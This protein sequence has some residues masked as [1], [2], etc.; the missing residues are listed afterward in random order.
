[1]TVDSD[2][3]RKRQL[4]LL[5]AGGIAVMVLALVGSLF[6]VHASFP[7]E[8]SYN[9]G[10]PFRY[11]RSPNKLK[12]HWTADTLIIASAY[13]ATKI[14]HQTPLPVCKDKVQSRLTLVK[15]VVVLAL[16]LIGGAVGIFWYV[17][18]FIYDPH[19]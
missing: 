8:R 2:V 4:I 5:G 9:C 6:P 16:L 18:G 11:W 17:Y 15:L 12:S 13:P 1:V 7:G 19:V 14:T 10:S 3:K